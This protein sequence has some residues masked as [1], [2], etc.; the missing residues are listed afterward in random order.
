M[1]EPADSGLQ[2]ELLLLSEQYPASPG[3]SELSFCPIFLASPM[4]LPRGELTKELAADEGVVLHAI[5][6]AQMHGLRLAGK[7]HT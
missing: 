4:S 2:E 6:P 1:P 5:S 3:D 7:V